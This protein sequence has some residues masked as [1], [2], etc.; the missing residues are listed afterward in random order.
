MRDIG[1]PLNKAYFSTLSALTYSGDSLRVF[2]AGSVPAEVTYPY[3]SIASRTGADDPDK[4]AFGT[5]VTQAV[6]VIDRFPVNT[7]T[8]TRVNDISNIIIGA[9]RKIKNRIDIGEDF[10]VI[11][12]TLDNTVTVIQQTDTYQYYTHQIRFRHKIEQ[13]TT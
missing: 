9:I 10:N 5:E 3:V 11:T 6:D 12:A 2:K 1:N 7:G 13:L 4:D 8:E